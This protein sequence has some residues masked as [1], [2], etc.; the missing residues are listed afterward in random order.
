MRFMLMHKTNASNEAGLRP[1]DELIAG[2]GRTIRE[3]QETGIF[4]DGAGLRAS[5][6]GARLELRGGARTVMPGPLTG[7]NEL[8][9]ALCVLRVGSLEGGGA[10]GL[11]LRRHRGRRRAGRPPLFE[12]AELR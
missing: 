6:L 8:P 2:V 12:F 4:R 7:K 9:A 1:P 11:A 3:M 5:S 10:L